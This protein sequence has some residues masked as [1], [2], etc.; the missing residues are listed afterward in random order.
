[1]DV[2]MKI[3]VYEQYHLW[4]DPHIDALKYEYIGVYYYPNN[5]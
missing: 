2:I 3:C 5:I 4:L 1:M